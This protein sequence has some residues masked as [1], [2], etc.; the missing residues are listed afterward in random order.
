MKNKGNPTLGFRILAIPFLVIGLGLLVI[1]MGG[2]AVEST[3]GT[4]GFF[5]IV[6]LILLSISFLTATASVGNKAISD[7]ELQEQILAELKKQNKSK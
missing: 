4:A 6:A 7:R 2:N 3:L 1:S 5:L